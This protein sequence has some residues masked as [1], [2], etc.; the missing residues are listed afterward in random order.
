MFK[1]LKLA[2]PLLLSE[3]EAYYD[4]TKPIVL[5]NDYGK[6]YRTLNCWEC[7]GA[8]GSMCSYPSDR[9]MI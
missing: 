6:E 8:Q 5:M 3:V 9:S 4:S 2:I 7:M 1:S